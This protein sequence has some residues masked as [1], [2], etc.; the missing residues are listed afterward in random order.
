MNRS[1]VLLIIFLI[2]FY[3]LAQWQPVGE[4]LPEGLTYTGCTEAITTKYNG[5]LY[6]VYNTID[7]NQQI[8]FQYK[9]FIAKWNGLF[10]AQMECAFTII[11]L[12]DIIVLGDEIYISSNNNTVDYYY[13]SGSF[14]GAYNLSPPNQKLISMCSTDSAVFMASEAYV[15][16]LSGSTA[17]LHSNFS[18]ISGIG[19]IDVVENELYLTSKNIM[20]P[21]LS[22]GWLYKYVNGQWDT[23][24]N[25]IS[26]PPLPIISPFDKN[27]NIFKLGQET[28]VYN[29]QAIYRK[30]NDTLSWVVSYTED[31]VGIS[32]NGLLAY[33][34]FRDNNGLI[35]LKSFNGFSINTIEDNLPPAYDFSFVDAFDE[36][37]FISS[38]FMYSGIPVNH[39]Y[40]VANNTGVLQLSFFHDVNRNCIR[41]SL[42]SKIPHTLFNINNVSFLTNKDGNYYGAH[43]VGVY[44]IDTLLAVQSK[45]KNFSSKCSFSPIQINLNQVTEEEIGLYID[46]T[47]VDIG[48]KIYSNT[49]WRSVKG[50][51][52]NYYLEITNYGSK[53][54]YGT[55]VLTQLDL[56]TLSNIS[57]EK[58]PATIN[59][60]VYTHLIDTLLPQNKISIPF[61][62]MV[63]P[64]VPVGSKINFYSML[65]VI[66]MDADVSDNSDT[67]RIEVVGPLDPNDKIPSDSV[68]LQSTSTID[69]HIRFQNIGSDTAYKVVIVDSLEITNALTSVVI[70]SSSHN[71]SFSVVDDVLI[72]EFN[73]IK[74]PSDKQNYKAS[75]G[76]VNFTVGINPNLGIG[77][78]FKNKALIY[79][80]Y[81]EPVHTNY[82]KSRVA[83]FISINESDLK[84]S[85]VKIYPSP[86]NYLLTL[87]NKGYEEYSVVIMNSKGVEICKFSL[88]KFERREIDV[89]NYPVGVY[90]L[91][92][93]K[94]VLKFIVTR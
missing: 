63:K 43:P 60:G 31:L 20:V 62:A 34:A 89:S 77:D 45:Y 16:K 3:L 32:S 57:F 4:G 92:T 78:I 5:E 1:I 27:K 30:S 84:I 76:Y 61:T 12:V 82:A 58:Q 23:I 85:G 24:V 37:I 83:E 35:D 93:E 44:Q 11:D 65:N 50:V 79:F 86:T 64:S 55:K 47:I 17:L 29:K 59:N 22:K 40:S 9:T 15:F 36:V 94:E 2:P 21:G 81:E 14:W 68:V 49:M 18:K 7:T 42:E 25:E 13:Y 52:Q 8:A 90:L 28:F 46:S 26:S 71:Y 48:I 53:P 75:Q 87:E 73:N 33:V 6:V 39:A 70:N 10:W 69:Y 56:S 88:K 91:Q 72:W 19:S 54:I 74:L 38:K 51:Q 66:P 41:D 67:L 80:D